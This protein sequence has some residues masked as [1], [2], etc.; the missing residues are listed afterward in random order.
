MVFK[1]SSDTGE[2]FLGGF[3]WVFFQPP[4]LRQRWT[5]CPW[6]LLHALPALLHFS[7]SKIAAVR[8]QISPAQRLL[9][10]TSAHSRESR[11]V[12]NEEKAVPAN[13]QVHSVQVFNGPIKYS[14]CKSYELP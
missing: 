10:I 14:K 5:H 9:G 7:T 3:C 13:H 12:R 2:P 6:M 1:R 11:G 4:A 8:I